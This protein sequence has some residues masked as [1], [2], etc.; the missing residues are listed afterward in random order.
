M[1]AFLR[2]RPQDPNDGDK[3]KDGV[4]QIELDLTI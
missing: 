1:D 3:R 2:G 4:K